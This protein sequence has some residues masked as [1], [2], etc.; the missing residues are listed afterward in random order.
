[1]KLT[2][3]RERLHAVGGMIQLH[4]FRGGG[5]KPALFFFFTKNK[6]NHLRHMALTQGGLIN[7]GRNSNPAL[8][9]GLLSLFWV[10]R[11]EKHG[12]LAMHISRK[13]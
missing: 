7:N 4:F 13:N 11:E 1:M 8:M 3:D 12:P 10:V 2:M 5:R 6:I 9:V